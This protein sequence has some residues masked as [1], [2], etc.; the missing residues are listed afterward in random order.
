[1]CEK[2][3][4]FDRFKVHYK[5]SPEAESAIQ[6]F[7]QVHVSHNGIVGGIF[8]AQE[9]NGVVGV[10]GPPDSDIR[11]AFNAMIA[12]ADKDYA[13]AKAKFDSAEAYRE[14][15]LKDDAS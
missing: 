15:M 3:H 2:C 1:M 9:V 10:M 6:S 14:A 11:K 5:Q 13:L 4:Q 12:E 8:A 7:I